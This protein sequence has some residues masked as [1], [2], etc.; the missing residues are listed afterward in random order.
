MVKRKRL[1]AIGLL[2]GALAVAACSPEAT[3]ARG[4][5]AGADVNN[6]TPSVDA[7]GQPNMYF[8]TPDLCPPGAC[9]PD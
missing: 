1:L 8:H 3:R 9:T 5:S 2:F 6:R 7:R 4:G